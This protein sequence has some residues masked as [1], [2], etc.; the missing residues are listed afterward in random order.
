MKLRPELRPPVLDESLVTHLADLANRIDGAQPGEWEELLDEFNRLAGTQCEFAHM[1]G[2][3][4]GEEHATFVRRILLEQ[5]ASA[6]D[7][8]TREDLVASFTHILSPECSEAER[9]FLFAQLKY[10]LRDP[11]IMD[12]VYWPGEYFGDGNNARALTPEAMADAA[13]QR[14][15]NL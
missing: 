15:R 3:S 7:D 12:L 5:R 9:D 8:L 1:Q 13:L 10:N 11:E 14:R 6:I 2:I 4:G